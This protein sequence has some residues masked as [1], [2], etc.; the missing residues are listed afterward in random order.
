MFN[1]SWRSTLRPSL[2]LTQR[3][4]VVARGFLNKYSAGQ[5]R[6]RGTDEAIAY[7][8]DVTRDMGSGLL[9]AGAQIG[10]VATRQAVP[11]AGDSTFSASSS[12]QS[13]YVHFAWRARPALSLSPGLR[14]SHSALLRQ[15]TLTPWILGEW[16]FQPRWTISASASLAHQAP[17]LQHVIGP[18]GSRDLR[19]ER[20]ASVDAGIEHR[21]TGA[22]DW[23]VT[24]FSRGESDV[25]RE[26]DLHP[27][28][29]GGTMVEPDPERY[30]SA[31]RGSSRGIELVVNLRTARGLSGSAAYSY[32]MTRYTDVERGETFWAD[33]D[34]R[35]A[36]TVAG[37]YR[38]SDR[39]SVGALLRASSGLPIPAYLSD[40]DGHLFVADRRNAVRLPPYA[41]MDLR[42]ER[43]FTRGD[44]HL[45]LFAELVNMANRTNLGIGNGVVNRVT[46][47][48]VEF[49]DGLFRR[50]AAAGILVEF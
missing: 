31:L 23:Q 46:G 25:L 32:G 41:R 30:V 49:T 34:Q 28:L 11:L 24:V 15:T 21:V 13:G 48:A 16:A 33:L 40:R 5:E 42:A 18:A 47:E 1:L 12:Q 19:P 4:Y 7:R 2:V 27:R 35:H 37:M 10:R 43:R 29:V 3:A 45:T 6:D 17:Q 14:L 50:R 20:A 22:L 9:E 36:L 38:L 26:P 8:A 44:R 39:T